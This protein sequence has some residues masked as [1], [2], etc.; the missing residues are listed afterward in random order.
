MSDFSSSDDQLRADLARLTA[1][2]YTLEQTI[3]RTPAGRD[4]ERLVSARVE[5]GVL[6]HWSGE[7][8]E[9]LKDFDMALALQPDYPPAHRQ[10]R[11][12]RTGMSW[13]GR[14]AALLVCHLHQHALE[15]LVGNG[16]VPFE[17]VAQGYDHQQ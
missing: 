7:L 3:A 10:R 15:W 8:P 14:R 5:L 1:R 17:G 2:V 12:V 16:E 4:R 13:Q 9:A 11:A 6:K